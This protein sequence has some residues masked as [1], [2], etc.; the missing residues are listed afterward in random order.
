MKHFEITYYALNTPFT[1]ACTTVKEAAD[2]LFNLA[3][4]DPT[5][6]SLSEI[7]DL[8]RVLVDMK[9]GS[10]LTY[11]QCRLYIKLVDGEI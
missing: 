2:A 4:V 9:F 1:Y 11:E 7:D 8:I 6:M 10:T 5:L 3:T